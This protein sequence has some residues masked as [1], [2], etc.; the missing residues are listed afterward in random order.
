MRSPSPL[1]RVRGR[2]TLRP[3]SSSP[4]PTSPRATRR[5]RRRPRPRPRPRPH[6]STPTDT[7]PAS[8]S[9]STLVP[10]PAPASAPALVPAP[11]PAPSPASASAPTPTTA[12]STPIVVPRWAPAAAIPSKNGAP[13]ATSRTRSSTRRSAPSTVSAPVPT[14]VSSSVR[15]SHSRRMSRRIRP[16]PLGAP[17]RRI[18]SLRGVVAS[19]SSR[20]HVGR[21]VIAAAAVSSA[22][23]AEKR[24]SGKGVGVGCATGTFSARGS[25]LGSMGYA[26]VSCH[27]KDALVR[28]GDVDDGAV[29]I[30]AVH[31]PEGVFGVVS[32]VELDEADAGGVGG[33]RGATLAGRGRAGRGAMRGSDST[34]VREDLLEV[35]RGDVLREVGDAKDARGR[36]AIVPRARVEILLVAL[37][38]GI[39]LVVRPRAPSARSRR[40]FGTRRRRAATEALPTHPARATL[41]GA[42]RAGACAPSKWESPS[43]AEGVSVGALLTKGFGV[44]HLYACS[45]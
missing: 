7:P 24:G 40:G 21:V 35:T 45:L 25:K 3:S 39:H 43:R 37:V 11:T 1:I 20:V 28:E 5:P 19:A 2:C 36:G 32:G 16:G 29:D 4:P 17:T 8:A 27:V 42:P 26:A 15:V 18:A 44:S 14:A 41:S 30:A 33:G 22:G 13:R 38:V 23:R 9:A 31:V 34:V 12:K 6:A 10:T